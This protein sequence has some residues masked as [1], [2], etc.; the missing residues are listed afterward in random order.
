MD[1]YLVYESIH[2]EQINQIEKLKTRNELDL[3]IQG[4][5]DNLRSFVKTTGCRNPSKNF[6]IKK[7]CLPRL[8]ADISAVWSVSTTALSQSSSVNRNLDPTRDFLLELHHTQVLAIFRVLC[9]DD[10]SSNLINNLAEVRTGEGKSVILAISASVLALLDSD[11]TIVCYSSSLGRRDRNEFEYL[12]SKLGVTGK[13]RYH[14]FD[15]LA[16][17]WAHDIFDLPT[18]FENQTYLS[19][20]KARS[21][22]SFLLIDEVDVFFHP[23]FFG[24][25]YNIACR[26]RSEEFFQLAWKIWKDKVQMESLS[27]LKEFRAF[28]ERFGNQHYKWREILLSAGQKMVMDVKNFHLHRYEVTLD[29]LIGY[30]DMDKI[31]TD[32]F[33]PYL[34][35][36][37]YFK[38]FENDVEKLRKFST[39]ML[40]CGK[41]S[42]AE[43]LRNFTGIIGVSGTIQ[44]LSPIEKE[45]LE[46][47]YGVVRFTFV[48]SA[49]GYEQL[50]FFS[51]EEAHLRIIKT[52]DD[53]HVT[54][55]QLID[56]SSKRGR[57]VLV[58]FKDKKSLLE[59]FES[60]VYKPLL[61]TTRVMTEDSSDE[62]RAFL[63]KRTNSGDITLLTRSFG[64]GTDFVCYDKK[65]NR[66]EVGGVHVIQTFISQEPSEEIQIKG[67]TTRQGKPGVYSIVLRLQEDLVGE[68]GLDPSLVESKCTTTLDGCYDFLMEQRNTAYLSKCK[69][70]EKLVHEKLQDHQNTTLLVSNILSKKLDEALDQMITWNTFLK[71]SGGSPK[72][73]HFVM[74]LDK[75]G[76]MY[77]EPWESLVSAMGYYLELRIKAGGVKDIITIVLYDHV[78]FRVIP[79]LPISE[80]AEIEGILQQVSPSGGTMFGPPINMARK[81]FLDDVGEDKAFLFLSDG[82]AYDGME[83]ISCMGSEFGPKGLKTFVFAFGE[84]ADHHKLQLMAQAHGHGAVFL[85]S[86]ISQAHVRSQMDVVVER[87]SDVDIRDDRKG[88]L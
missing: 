82:Q 17:S 57:A 58:F 69:A 55:S 65:V 5:V 60:D 80:F 40:V 26:I 81:I 18:Y 59:L 77:G 36:F 24:H 64:R 38:E 7:S 43:I 29:G 51:K 34:T 16:A 75:S 48:P 50:S 33:F 88:P 73:V 85:F 63:V 4:V 20:F 72:A 86:D 9:L 66:P 76:S 84:H 32:A 52:S 79:R 10:N 56:A 22:F 53:F 67:R 42:Y 87:V 78:L 49:F 13:I 1:S 71:F 47:Y 74:A 6:S 3:Y 25:T 15:T 31:N 23:R 44:N 19:N 61:T 46:G 12:Y 27:G 54:L 28:L 70:K 14:S 68:L 11:V 41:Y 30:Q 45:I 37:A 8:I 83:E 62:E 35:L 2:M 39:L 21:S